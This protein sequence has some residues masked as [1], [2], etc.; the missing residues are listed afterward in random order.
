MDQ[1]FGDLPSKVP[2][3]LNGRPRL[4]EGKGRPLKGK[5]AKGFLPKGIW[6]L[7]KERSWPK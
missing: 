7:K 3:D 5:F 1:R 4:K 2:K 6:F